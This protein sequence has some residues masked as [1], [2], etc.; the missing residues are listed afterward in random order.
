MARSIPQ[1]ILIDVRTPAEFATGALSSDLYDAMN[2]EYQLIEQLPQVYAAL[3]I[4]VRK[5]Y[6]ITLYC[7]SG[8]RSNIALQTLR[9]LG[10]TNVRDIGGFEE[11]RAILKREELGRKSGADV[12]AAMLRERKEEEKNEA[13]VNSFGSLFHGL[14]RLEVERMQA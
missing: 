2:I 12:K 3:G 1:E 9:G 7:R 13:R 5:S 10:Y 4:H 11:A 8:R 6:A 14:K